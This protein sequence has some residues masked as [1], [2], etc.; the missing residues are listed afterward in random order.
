MEIPKATGCIM[1]ARYGKPAC[2]SLAC[3]D[4]MTLVNVFQEAWKDCP[5]RRP[6]MVSV[7]LVDLVP[8][9]MRNMTLFDEMY[10]A[11]KI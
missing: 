11:E 1:T 7:A 10:G 8:E 3:H 5:K 4:T 9:N 2:A 6:V